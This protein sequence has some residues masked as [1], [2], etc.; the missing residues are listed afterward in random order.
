MTSD[1]V[2]PRLMLLSNESNTSAVCSWG[3]N[4]A[5]H[6]PREAVTISSFLFDEM[7]APDEDF[8]KPEV[9]LDFEVF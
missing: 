5:L 2:F 1:L 6:S 9:P 3:T 7:I 4:E 8:F